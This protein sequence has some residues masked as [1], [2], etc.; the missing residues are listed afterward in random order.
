MQ[1]KLHHLDSKQ[2]KGANIHA[3][4]RSELEG[5]NYSKTFF[6]IADSKICKIKQFLNF[7]RRYTDNKHARLSSNPE[8]IL[9]PATNFLTPS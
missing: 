3:N 2:S 5:G 6:E 1:E 8:E 7:I 9:R 4:I